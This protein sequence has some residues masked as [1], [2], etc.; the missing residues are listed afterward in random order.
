MTNG[1]TIREKV[2]IQLGLHGCLTATELSRLTKEKLSSVSSLLRKM[3]DRGEL[4]FLEGFGPRGGAGYG[5]RVQNTKKKETR[6]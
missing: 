1:V 4:N 2:I 3:V 5:L 6:K